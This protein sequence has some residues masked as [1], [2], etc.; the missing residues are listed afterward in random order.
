MREEFR[1]AIEALQKDL[2]EQERKVIETKTTINRLCELAGAPIIYADV[3]T[4][5]QASIGNLRADTFYG[6]VLNT[7]MRECL[8]MRRAANLGPATPRQ[9]YE[10]I[11]AGG[12]KF[13]TKSEI[14]ALVNIRATLRKNSSIFHRLPNGEYGLLGWY[15]GVKPV[16]Q[17]VASEDS[18]E[19]DA[20]EETSDTE[21]DSAEAHE[22]SAA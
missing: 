10:V 17:S 20:E 1:P 11:K 12:F 19:S 16:R 3:G 2:V 5:S 8:E 4:P 14:N 21:Q 7:A 13:D 9:I 6:K 15:P 22:P 18:D